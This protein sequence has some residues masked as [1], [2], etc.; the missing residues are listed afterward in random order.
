MQLQILKREINKFLASHNIT[1]RCY[2]I[3][4]AL[5]PSFMITAS[6]KFEILVFACLAF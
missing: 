5:L 2:V 1:Q 3:F 4:E 6:R